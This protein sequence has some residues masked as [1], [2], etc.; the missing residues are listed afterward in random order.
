[1]SAKTVL[2]CVSIGLFVIALW[3]MTMALAHSR[4]K[5]AKTQKSGKPTTPA[6]QSVT[7]KSAPAK[8]V[9]TVISPEEAKQQVSLDYKW[10]KDGFGTIMM[11]DLVFINPSPYPA[12]DITVTC[13]HYAPSGTEIDSNTRTIYEVVPA[14]GVKKVN[15]FNMGFIHSQASSTRCKIDHL[16]M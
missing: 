10:S 14:K 8:P 9:P 3:V 6:E 13:T 12:K 4:N 11:V 7:E 5:N 1:M 2:I 15:D 16:E